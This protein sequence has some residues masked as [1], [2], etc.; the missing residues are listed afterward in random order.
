MKKAY[1]IFAHSLPHQLNRFAEQLTADSD[2]DVYIHIS[3]QSEKMK[4]EVIQNPHIFISE[5]NIDTP[6]GSDALLNAMLIMLNEV[7]SASNQYDYII[8]CS[9]QDLLVRNDLD[10][11]LVKNKGK[12]FVDGCKDNKEQ[13]AR[14]LYKWPI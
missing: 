2:S 4:T 1:I 3:K 14:L 7:L 9:G 11:F 8:F 13:R 6:W 12:V 10:L 5:R